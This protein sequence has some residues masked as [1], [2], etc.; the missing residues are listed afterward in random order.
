LQLVPEV[1][2]Y[3][4]KYAEAEPLYRRAWQIK[5]KRLGASYP[6]VARDLTAVANAFYFQE[7]LVG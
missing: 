4:G 7:K 5:E 2:R 1:Y 6:N 3:E